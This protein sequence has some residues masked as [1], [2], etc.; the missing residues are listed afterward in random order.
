M[1][2][3]DVPMKRVKIKKTIKTASCRFIFIFLSSRLTKGSSNNA[4]IKASIIGMETG[5]MKKALIISMGMNMMK[6]IVRFVTKLDN[7]ELLSTGKTHT[8]IRC[9]DH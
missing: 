3:P 4:V 1:K 8:F 6:K 7:E 5:K 2:K 9:I